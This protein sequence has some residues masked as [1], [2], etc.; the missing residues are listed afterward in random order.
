MEARPFGPQF[1]SNQVVTLVAGVAQMR[2]LS[3]DSTAIRVLNSGSG[4]LYIRAYSS[5]SGAP[6]ASTADYPILSGMVSTLTIGAAFDRISMLSTS[7]TTAQV[8][9]GQGGV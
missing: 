6:V 3:S 9:T 1:G 2:T 8:M 7:G 4:D 5:Q